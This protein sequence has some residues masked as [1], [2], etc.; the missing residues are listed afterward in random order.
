[1]KR[2]HL[3]LLFSPI[4]WFCDLSAGEFVS[5]LGIGFNVNTQKLR[6]DMHSGRFVYGGSPL[7]LRYNF[8]PAW[9]LD[10]DI[11]FGRLSTRINGALLET[12]M[13]NFGGKLGYRFPNLPL[14]FIDF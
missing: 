9:F 12:S 13:L 10:T 2:I 8:K 6:G 5:K 11:G 1:M 3:I 7:L 4:L 14:D